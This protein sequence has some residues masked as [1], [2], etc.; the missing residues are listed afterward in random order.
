[1]AEII[2]ALIIMPGIPFALIF[3]VYAICQ[4]AKP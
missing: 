3:I 4:A 1:M 2:I